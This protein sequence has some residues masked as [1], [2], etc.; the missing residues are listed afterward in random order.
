M[1]CK[2]KSEKENISVNLKSTNFISFDISKLQTSFA[3]SDGSSLAWKMGGLTNEH[4]TV[5]GRWEDY[6]LG[7]ENYDNV[8]NERCQLH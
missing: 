5:G 2:L 4:C 7:D 8:A 3:Q 1:F 6:D